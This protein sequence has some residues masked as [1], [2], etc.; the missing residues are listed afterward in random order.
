MRG[1]SEHSSSRAPLEVAPEKHYRYFPNVFQTVWEE[2]TSEQQSQKRR[3]FEHGYEKPLYMS[4][5]ISR[6]Q[7]AGMA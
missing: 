3:R 4:Y 5:T 7:S 2:P 6:D 1:G